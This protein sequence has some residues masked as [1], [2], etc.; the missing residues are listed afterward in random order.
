MKMRNNYN[1]IMI[2]KDEIIS[3]GIGK[4]KKAQTRLARNGL[5]HFN[6]LT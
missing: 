2:F 6:V 5:I 4:S 1:C 3:K